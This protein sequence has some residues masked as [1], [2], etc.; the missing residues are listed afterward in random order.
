MK[1]I[2]TIAFF[3]IVISWILKE[4]GCLSKFDIN[5]IKEVKKYLMANKFQEYETKTSTTS[6]LI[7]NEIS[8]DLEIYTGDKNIFGQ[9]YKYQIGEKGKDYR[10]LVFE[11]LDGDWK[12]KDDGNIYLWNKGELFIFSAFGDTKKLQTK[13]YNRGQFFSYGS[14]AN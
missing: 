4:A 5:S 12:V 6:F 14:I 1:K 10:K 8:M 11:G 7:F 3:L 13:N 9:H 2:I